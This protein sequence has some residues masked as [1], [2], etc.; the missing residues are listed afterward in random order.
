MRNPN[1]R[2]QLLDAAIAVLA[3]RGGRGL[4]H[5]A[6]DRQAGVP[7]GT[8]SNYF[9][10]RAALV[11]ELIDRI[12]ERLAPTQEVAAQLSART[13]DRA[14]YADYLRDIVRRL[15]AQRTVTLALFELRLEAARNPEVAES[16]GAFLR[17]AFADD[18]E[19]AR[20]AQLP[21]GAAE[22]ALFHYALDGFLLDRLTTPVHPDLSSDEVVDRLVQG[23]L[24][25]A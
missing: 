7:E 17:Q 5:R 4:T 15:L 21:G 1:R 6:V 19:F 18:T 16:I 9:R 2:K 20:K 14:L 10:T 3:D 25:E 23:L 11:S 12:Y 24:P 22:V 13:P 8:A